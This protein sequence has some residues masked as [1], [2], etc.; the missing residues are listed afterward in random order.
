MPMRRA[1]V[2]T[3]ASSSRSSWASTSGSSPRSQG[4]P[5]Q[6]S[7]RRARWSAA[8]QQDHVGAGRSQ[9]R[10]LPRVDHEL[11]GQDRQR[12][13]GAGGPQVIERAA[14][15]VGLDEHGDDRRTARLVGTRAVGDVEV[16]H[17]RAARP[18]VSVA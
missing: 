2:A 6:S 11:L 5:S 4:Q 12:G 1:S 15:P 18:M 10:Q 16:C 8:E 9:D 17:R 13:R 3:A 14:E 7:E